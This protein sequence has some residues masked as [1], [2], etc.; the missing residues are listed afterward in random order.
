MRPYD[1]N[2]S[3]Y[4]VKMVWLVLAIPAA[5]VAGCMLTIYLAITYPDVLIDKKTTPEYSQKP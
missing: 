3:W 1:E 4:K 5:C 2:Q